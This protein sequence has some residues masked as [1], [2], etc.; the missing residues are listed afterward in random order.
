MAVKLPNS[1]LDKNQLLNVP[2]K[3]KN[4]HVHRNDKY[5]GKALFD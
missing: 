5:I 3:Q 1:V 4:R 2:L